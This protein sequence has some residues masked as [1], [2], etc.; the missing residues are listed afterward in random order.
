MIEK[1]HT[2]ANDEIDANPRLS[3]FIKD[4]CKLLCQRAM[5]QRIKIRLSFVRKHGQSQWNKMKE[6]P[7]LALQSHIGN[8]LP[9]FFV[10]IEQFSQRIVFS[11]YVFFFFFETKIFQKQNFEQN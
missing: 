4:M 11:F 1:V 8:L 6:P 7:N 5:Q 10:P 2:V 9:Y 3:I